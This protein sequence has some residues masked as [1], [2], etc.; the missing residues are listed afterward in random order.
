MNAIKEPPSSKLKDL[1]DQ[2]IRKEACFELLRTCYDRLPI[3]EVHASTAAIVIAYCGPNPSPKE[4]TT[5][6]IRLGAQSKNE[7]VPP[8]EPKELGP[9]R[10]RYHQA[11]YNALSFP[12]LIGSRSKEL[13]FV[14]PKLTSSAKANCLE[15][16]SSWS[17]NIDHLFEELSAKNLLGM[18]EYRN[19]ECQTSALVILFTI[20]SGLTWK[21][22]SFFLD[23][24]I[25][26]FVNHPSKRARQAFY[27]LITRLHGKELQTPE[28]EK[29]EITGRLLKVGLLR[30]LADP[31]EEIRKGLFDYL[32][33]DAGLASS[34]VFSKMKEILKYSCIVVPVLKRGICARRP[35]ISNGEHI[36]TTHVVAMC[37]TQR[38]QKEPLDEK[39]DWPQ[40]RAKLKHEELCSRA[41]TEL[42]N[43][44]TF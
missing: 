38:K 25:Q 13:L 18:L 44:L 14:L 2:L 40:S 26:T 33:R 36:V 28:A 43:Y 3:A 1:G 8:E 19:E 23:L 20:A 12:K 42:G 37:I 5:T 31:D 21:Q 4:L 10:L 24:I 29:D 34:D 9:L 16:L 17:D 7:R 39:P 22:V 27:S 15:A 35:M 30:G 11:A 32:H 41:R 6:I